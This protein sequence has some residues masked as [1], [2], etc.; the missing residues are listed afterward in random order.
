M[1]TSTLKFPW[2]FL[3]TFFWWCSYSFGQYTVIPTTTT[4]DID[5]IEKI[6]DHIV[7]MAHAQYLV[8]CTGNCDSLESV[9]PSGMYTYGSM[10]NLKLLDSNNYYFITY[11]DIL[12]YEYSQMYHTNDG[13]LTWS[14][15]EL[16]N[17]VAAS[18]L[19]VFDSTRIFAS[20]NDQTYFT[21]DNG[22][23]WNLG[24]N[25]PINSVSA[26]FVLND[27]VAYIGGFEQ[28]ART[29]DGGLSWDEDS[30][31]QIQ[32]YKFSTST[33][34]SLFFVS[35]GGLNGWFSYL[36]NNDLASRTDRIIP[37]TLPIGI[38]VVSSNEIYVCGRDQTTLKG[39]ILKT[40]DLGQTWTFFDTQELRYLE[41][42]VPVNDSI[43]LIGGQSG[44]LIKWNKYS[45]MQDLSLNT[46][47]IK[48]KGELNIYP[49]PTS[50][51]QYI[52]FNNPLNEKVEIKVFDTMG[53]EYNCI[54][55]EM[56][57]ENGKANI[58]LTNLSKGIYL[59]RINM[60]GLTFYQTFQKL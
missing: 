2:I 8:K 22:T 58:K 53:R 51:I 59:Y 28:L 42:L 36:T 31:G 15:S 18:E 55:E 25:T 50:S 21:F 29:M 45:S 38:Y 33:N 44:F 4:I 3:I 56:V 16:P 49:N 7:V 9:L 30:I 34:D 39:R 48:E 6:D 13:G 17:F 19:L 52:E 24:I 40:T 23:N 57:I 43:F 54:N 37:G 14:F 47:N 26:S 5:E 10:N 32:P 41:D 60:G 35:N 1:Y 11:S 20:E 27:T 12:P 46:G